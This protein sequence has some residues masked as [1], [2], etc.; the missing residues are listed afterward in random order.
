MWVL[1]GAWIELSGDKRTG[2][3]GTQ[4]QALTSL[5]MKTSDA[6]KSATLVT[7]ASEFMWAPSEGVARGYF[8]LGEMPMA[9]KDWERGVD[10]QARV[11]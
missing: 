9:G 5:V 7:M 3:G 10:E 4:E 1:R 11:G 2:R 6:E 8:S